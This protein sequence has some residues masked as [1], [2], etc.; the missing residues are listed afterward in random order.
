MATFVMQSLG[1]DVA[2]INTVQFSKSMA[3]SLFSAAIIV[4]DWELRSSEGFLRH[5]ISAASLEWPRADYFNFDLQATIPDI[6]NL[7]VDERLPKKSLSSTM[8][9][10]NPT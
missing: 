3:H 10:A 5:T 8:A 6:S 2:A 7:K 4:L 1:C 9:C